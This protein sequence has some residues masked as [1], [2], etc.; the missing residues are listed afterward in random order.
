MP[1]HQQ[2]SKRVSV[3]WANQLTGTTVFSQRKIQ[4]FPSMPCE[5]LLAALIINR[6]L[7]LSV[8]HAPLYPIFRAQFRR[9][10]GRLLHWPRFERHEE[11]DNYFGTVVGSM[12]PIIAFVTR[13]GFGEHV[14]RDKQSYTV[15]SRLAEVLSKFIYARQRLCCGSW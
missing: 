3:N 15:L 10:S 8:S 9:L 2:L 1:A 14:T 5:F 4:V 7:F 6:W 12:C 11:R 13:D